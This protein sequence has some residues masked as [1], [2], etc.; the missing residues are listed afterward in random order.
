MPVME[1][2][3]QERPAGIKASPKRA[4]MPA[5][6]AAQARIGAGGS[7]GAWVLK[8]TLNTALIHTGIDV[9][10]TGCSEICLITDITGTGTGTIALNH[11]NLIN[12]LIANGRRYGFV[13]F[14]DEAIGL[15]P[16]I[17][18][19]SPFSS[20]VLQYDAPSAIKRDLKVSDVTRVDIPLS[21]F[22]TECDI[23]IYAR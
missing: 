21:D 6:A 20:D 5:K 17:G 23:K 18:R 19:Y 12:N 15:T 8:G 22:V 10:L 1:K 16:I 11:N 7:G 9:D 4:A 13:K 3:S 2:N 14:V